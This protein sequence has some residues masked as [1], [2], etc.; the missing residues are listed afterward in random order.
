MQRLYTA[1]SGDLMTPE[2]IA[3]L[4]AAADEAIT[5]QKGYKEI[6]D[7]AH[8]HGASVRG[9]ELI[10]QLKAASDAATARLHALIDAQADP[11]GT[12]VS[13]IR[14][15]QVAARF[16]GEEGRHPVEQA[17]LYEAAP[18]MLE[19]CRGIVAVEPQTCAAA[20]AAIRI[21]TGADAHEWDGIQ[22]AM[23]E[24]GT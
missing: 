3:A 4:H 24:E 17:Q 14:N 19:V 7:H 21:A 5:T 18:A 9:L 20:R 22:A 2:Q 10:A 8:H 16:Y 13:F 15:R 1:L 6:A 12:V 23:E 11:E